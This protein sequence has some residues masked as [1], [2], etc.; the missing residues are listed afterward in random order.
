V[1]KLR[2]TNKIISKITGRREHKFQSINRSSKKTAYFLEGSHNFVSPN[3]ML[4]HLMNTNDRKRA[5]NTISW[6]NKPD[7]G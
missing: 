7:N 6:L 1:K 4:P 2:K 3:R 5:Q